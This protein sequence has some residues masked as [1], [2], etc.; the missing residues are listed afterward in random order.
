MMISSGLVYHGRKMFLSID[1]F[2]ILFVALLILFLWEL[3]ACMFFAR[4]LP[5]VS[6]FYC[7]LVYSYL[8][9]SL[10]LGGLE[11]NRLDP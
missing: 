11:D 7:S 2:F 6:V 10:P 3:Y 8:V 1:A 5:E 4:G 9:P